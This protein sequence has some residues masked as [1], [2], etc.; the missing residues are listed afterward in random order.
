ML[1]YPQ[2]NRN[3]E[4][5]KTCSCFWGEC[6]VVDL[7]ESFHL[8]RQHGNEFPLQWGEAASAFCKWR[9]A[10]GWSCLF[11]G[12]SCPAVPRCMFSASDCGRCFT[13]QL[14]PLGSRKH[15]KARKHLSL[16][17]HSDTKPIQIPSQNHPK[18]RCKN[19]SFGLKTWFWRMI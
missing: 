19:K 10:G 9:N 12:F 4:V 18:A 11:H 6:Q 17:G 2:K 14:L 15:R 7:D 16:P 13:F 1:S 5:N 3:F 8:V